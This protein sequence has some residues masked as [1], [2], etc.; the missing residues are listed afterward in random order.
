MLRDVVEEVRE[1]G[2]FERVAPRV[3]ARVESALHAEFVALL[4]RNPRE[5]NYRPVAAT[6]IGQAPPPGS[7]RSKKCTVRAPRRTCFCQTSKKVC[8]TSSKSAHVGQRRAVHHISFFKVAGF[9]WFVVS[10]NSGWRI[11]LLL[12]YTGR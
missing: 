4:V 5:P 9:S 3:V 10:E 7:P 12:F 11:V 1:A 8:L 2:S 6:P